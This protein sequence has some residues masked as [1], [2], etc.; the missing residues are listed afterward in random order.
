MS[1]GRILV[2]DD[3]RMVRTAVGRVL[4]EE[5]YAVSYAVDGHD[6]LVKLH[7]DRPDAI[8]LDVMMPGMNGREFLKTLREHHDHDIPVVVMTAIHGIDSQPVFALGASDL[9]KKPFDADELLNKVAL[10]LFRSRAAER[11][12]DAPAPVEETGE[13]A[14]ED[15]REGV[16]LVI[17]DDRLTLRRLDAMLNERGYTTVSLLRV[18]DELPRLA[19]VLEPA[20]ILLD[21]R[22]PGIDGVTALRWLRAERML[23]GVPILV[24]SASEDELEQHRAEIEKLGAEIRP[25]PLDVDQLVAF[26]TSPPATASRRR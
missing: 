19:R 25:K 13:T 16:V 12:P 22:M 21:L 20:A 2:V 10:A 9:V 26:V 11:V 1:G 4:E 18:T 24:F 5:G 17:D 6:A 15:S 8:L 14:I 7:G 23:D 3:D